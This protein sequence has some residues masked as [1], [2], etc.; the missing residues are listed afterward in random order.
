M[1]V[2]AAARRQ[3]EDRARQDASVGG[4]DDEV[5]RERTEIVE[6]A[7]VADPLGLQYGHAAR[8]GQRLHRRRLDREPP[9]P[10]TVGLAD[11][12]DHR[13]G[14]PEQGLENRPGEGRRPHEEDAPGRRGAQSTL[15]RA[16]APLGRSA[17]RP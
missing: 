1:H 6:D 2:D 11:D 15:R 9:A 5:G 17:G 7:R 14:P 12:A 13:I 16:L 10:R 8:Q 3:V 4:H